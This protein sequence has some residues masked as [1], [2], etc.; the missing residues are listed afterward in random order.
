VTGAEGTAAGPL[1]P[2]LAAAFPAASRADWEAAVETALRGRPFDSLVSST[3]G[4]VDV[5]PLYVPAET[6]TGHD[7]SGFPGAA[8]GTRGSVAVPRPDGRWDVRRPVDEADAFAANR[9]ALR[10]LERGVTSLEVP[11]PPASAADLGE[12]LDG[13]LLDLAPVVLRPGWDFESG[14]AALEDL[15]STQGLAPEAALGGFGADPFGTLAASGQGARPVGEALTA[16]ATLAARTAAARPRV[17]AMTVSSL[18]AFEAGASEVLELAVVLSTGAAYLRELSSVGLDADTATAQIEVEVAADADVFTT[19][20]KVRAVR[21]VWAGLAASCGATDPAGSLRL[22]VRTGRRMMTSRDPWVNLLRVTAAAF[23]AGVA[24]ADSVTTESY[25]LLLAEH[26]ELGR[27]MAR[28]TQ[29]LLIEESNLGRVAD[30][31]GGSAFLE[32]LTEQIASA[33]WGRFQELEAA[34]GIGATLVDGTLAARITD[35]RNAQLARVA[36]RRRPITGVSEFPDADESAPALAADDG[37]TP[38]LVPVRWAEGYEDLRAAADAA[39]GAGRSVDVFL[40]NLGP[41]AVH[42]ARATFA[43]NLFAAGGVRAVTGEAGETSGYDDDATLVADVE[44]SGASLVCICSSD[45]VYAERAAEVAAAVSG[46]DGVRRVYLA[47]APGEDRAQLEQAGVD[48][49]IHVGVDALD[50]LRRAQQEC[51]VGTGGAR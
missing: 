6:P 27:R 29:L 38:L 15:W 12:R 49:F 19:L 34:G 16:A 2:P 40:A 9:A 1:L 13:V 47:G 33:A 22:T 7:E 50:V 20:A 4:G 32:T 35:E 17:R 31:A 3:D 8:P 48:E 25:D 26:G 43:R 42:T 36:T 14:A 44:E 10:D 18:P 23:A 5:Q 45:A 11:F 30:P 24:G 21:R 28:N 46:L 41:V 37:G 51:G 39:R